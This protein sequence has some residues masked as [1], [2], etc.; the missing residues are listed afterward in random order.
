[1]NGPRP[2]TALTPVTRGWLTSRLAVR[3][4]VGGVLSKSVWIPSGA[5]TNSERS[6]VA[7]APSAFACTL[8]A[9]VPLCV[10]VPVITPFVPSVSP[11]GN[12][13]PA[14][15]HEVTVAPVAVRPGDVY[16]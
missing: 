12:V 5:R 3:P 6:F 9:K 1:M 13:P 10:G 2:P 4:V 16:A 7:L 15:V 8:T 11:D 14:S